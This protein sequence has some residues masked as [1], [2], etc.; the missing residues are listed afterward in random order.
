MEG[1]LEKMWSINTV[2]T[3][4]FAVG[5]ITRT[6]DRMSKVEYAEAYLPLFLFI[7]ITIY[8]YG[9]ALSNKFIKALHGIRLEYIPKIER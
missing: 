9:I 3:F 6:F 7:F 5:K 1:N 4:F 8:K 2:C